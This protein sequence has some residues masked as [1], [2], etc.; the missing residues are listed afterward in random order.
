MHT[1][2]KIIEYGYICGFYK[3]SS[4]STTTKN[5]LKLVGKKKADQMYSYVSLYFIVKC[6]GATSYLFIYG[7]P[8]TLT[9]NIMVLATS[10]RKK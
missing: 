9:F 10:N 7:F 6:G 4:H 5:I 2:L 3:I 8:N 1:K